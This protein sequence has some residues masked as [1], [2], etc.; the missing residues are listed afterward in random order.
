MGESID[1][2]HEAGPRTLL[3]LLGRVYLCLINCAQ[4]D[5]LSLFEHH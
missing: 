1:L 2:V 4:L 5:F 3:R